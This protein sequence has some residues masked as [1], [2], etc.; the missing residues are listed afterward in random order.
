MAFDAHPAV[1]SVSS[2]SEGAGAGSEGA[3]TTPEPIQSADKPSPIQEK[4]AAAKR[5]LGAGQPAAPAPKAPAPKA[6]AP[7]APEASQAPDL[8]SQ[9]AGQDP[10][11]TPEAGDIDPATNAPYEPNFKFEVRNKEHEIAEFLRGAI[12]NPEQEK[13]VKELYEKSMGLD[14]IKPRHQELIQ[15]HT[16]LEQ[17]FTGLTTQIGELRDAYHRGDL[18]SFFQKMKVSEEKVLQWVMEK[19]KYLEMPPEQR[20]VLDSRKEAEQRAMML[21]KQ[22]QSLEAKFEEQVASAK[23]YSLQ[24]ALEKPDVQ[25]FAEKFDQ[26]GI[27]NRE[28]AT[29]SFYDA[30]CEA[31]EMAWY[32]SHGKVDL[33]PEQAIEEV[34]NRYS[35]LGQQAQKPSAPAIIPP[36]GSAQQ[37]PKA[38]PA[39]KQT[40]TLPNVAG[41]QQSSV[42]KSQPRSIEDL[43]RIRAQMM[44]A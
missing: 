35:V 15:R 29:L 10:S 27:K 11:P 17:N 22:N 4:I 7:K 34:M 39:P 40:N 37:A 2:M 3:Q 44:G 24:V 14:V 25:T 36:Q 18:D 6:P 26:A 12:T 38:A 23:A 42:S 41:R 21:E 33:T 9:P 28:G 13:A 43:K 32:A 19:A 8:N 5:N 30:V 20:A 31:G 1:E 16:Q